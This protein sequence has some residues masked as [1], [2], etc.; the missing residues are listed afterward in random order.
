MSTQTS[1]VGRQKILKIAEQL[2]TERGYRA[3]S[4]RD[5]AQACG[6]TN[7]A[8]YY[9]FSN[10]EALFKEVLELYTMRLGNRMRAAASDQESA[11]EKVEAMLSEYVDLVAARRSLFFSLHHKPAGLS[12]EDAHQQR[13][14]LMRTI[15][16]PLE[17]ALTQAVDSG[18]LRHLPAGYS[19]SSLLFGML[20]GMVQHRRMY[21]QQNLCSDDVRV[22]VDVL[23]NGMSG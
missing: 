4:V 21:H 5:I 1:P 11:R 10:K 16:E 3:V 2:F 22:V 17:D 14:Q 18:E 15:L 12:K 9:H 20:H 8:L 13:A 23:W 7:A 19:A 6:V